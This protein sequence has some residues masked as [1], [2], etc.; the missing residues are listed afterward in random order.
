MQHSGNCSG[1]APISNQNVHNKNREKFSGKL[2]TQPSNRN[3]TLVTESSVSSLCIRSKCFLKAFQLL[4]NLGQQGQLISLSSKWNFEKCLLMF[5]LVIFTPQNFW[6]QRISRWNILKAK[7]VL[8]IS[9]FRAT[10]WAFIWNVR[11]SP[12]E[13]EDITV[14]GLGDLSLEGS[15]LG[16]PSSSLPSASKTSLSWFRSHSSC[17]LSLCEM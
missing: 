14:M 15:I 8:P 16:I 11:L 10:R 4:K 12:R 13:A 5:S 6:G 2:L 7:F 17:I 3:A 1:S 9:S